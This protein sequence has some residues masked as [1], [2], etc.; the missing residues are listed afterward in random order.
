MPT[1]ILLADDHP[2]IRAAVELLLRGSPYE[3]VG[4]ASTGAQALEAIAAHDP[5][6]VDP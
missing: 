6:I 1:R 4:R 2:M 5:D 3:L